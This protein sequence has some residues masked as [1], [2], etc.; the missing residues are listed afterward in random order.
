MPKTVV[1]SQ[2]N[3]QGTWISASYQVPANVSVF[4]MWGDVAPNDLNS[5][6]TFRLAVESSDDNGQTWAPRYAFGFAGPMTEQP[7]LEVAASAFAGQ[8]VRAVL[9]VPETMRLGATVDVE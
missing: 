6:K 9:D 5:T 4:R 3:R 2:A 1:L 7:Y 8:R